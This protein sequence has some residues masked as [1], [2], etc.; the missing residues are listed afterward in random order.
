ME[1][2]DVTTDVAVHPSDDCDNGDGAFE[3]GR[4]EIYIYIYLST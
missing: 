1:R 3:L 2:I 4:E